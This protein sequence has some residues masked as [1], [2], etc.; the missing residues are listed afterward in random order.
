MLT[1]LQMFREREYASG[2]QHQHPVSAA[3]PAGAVKA[4]VSG[5]KGCVEQRS[6]A[7]PWIE[8]GCMEDL[9]VQVDTFSPGSAQALQES[10]R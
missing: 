6:F 5:R 4:A 9:V 7:G 2:L 8:P 10:T 3:G 1:T